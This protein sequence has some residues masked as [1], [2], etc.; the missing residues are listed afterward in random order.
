MLL[1]SLSFPFSVFLAHTRVQTHKWVAIHQHS[2]TTTPLQFLPISKAWWNIAAE[3]SSRLLRVATEHGQ[4][5]DHTWWLFRS[6]HYYPELQ[7]DSI[8]I[9]A[10]KSSCSAA[11][12][13]HTWK[14]QLLF[15][16][17]LPATL[18]SFANLLLKYMASQRWCLHL[19]FS[20]HHFNQCKLSQT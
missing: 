17:N 1:S 3:H 9:F 8:A 14:R 4:D 2:S 15:G 5:Q 18:Q 20:F 7:L 19:W 13:Q 6:L 12:E 16:W 11:R 10:P